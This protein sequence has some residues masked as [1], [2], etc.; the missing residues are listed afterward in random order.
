[1]RCERVAG[2]M[3]AP[4]R[5]LSQVRPF[6]GDGSNHR[7]RKLAAACNLWKLKWSRPDLGTESIARQEV[8]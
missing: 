2:M 4:T 1:M 6:A 5:N 3:H 7:A 8:C